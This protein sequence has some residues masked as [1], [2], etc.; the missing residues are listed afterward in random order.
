MQLAVI[1]PAALTVARKLTSPSRATSTPVTVKWLSALAAAWRTVS[2]SRWLAGGETPLAAVTVSLCRPMTLPV[3]MPEM[4]AVPWAASATK[5]RPC[6]SGPFSPSD[7]TGNPVAMST[8]LPGWPRTKE[9]L[10]GE[11]IAGASRTV[12]MNAW[13]ADGGTPFAAVT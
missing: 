13:T 11:T 4:I 5:L 9:S 8:R 7:G 6:G 10:G 1:D 2:V 12:N 3:G